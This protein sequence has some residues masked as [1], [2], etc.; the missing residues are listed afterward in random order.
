MKE[1]E[2]GPKK[3]TA[4]NGTENQKN[5]QTKQKEAKKKLGKNQDRSGEE[6]AERA[7]SPPTPSTTVE[8]KNSKETTSSVRPYCASLGL[9]RRVPFLS[10]IAGTPGIYLLFVVCWFVFW[11]FRCRVAIFAA[12]PSHSLRRYRMKGIEKE[13]EARKWTLSR[14]PTVRSTVYSCDRTP[15]Q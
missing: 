4:Q 2:N 11:V 8:S 5:K 15:T 7:P 10:A 13:R 1:K 14:R 6:F 12:G 9:R 3:K